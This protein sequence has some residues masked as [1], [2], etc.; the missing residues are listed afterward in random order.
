MAMT[1]LR[2]EAVAAA[3]EVGL[4]GHAV[5]VNAA[6]VAEAEDLEAA[7]VGQDGAVPG[8]EAVQPA[9]VA[10]EF[11]AGA[12]VEVVGVGQHQRRPQLAQIARPHRLDRGL[13]ADGGED[14]GF[15]RAVG[16]VEAAE[17]G[18]AVGGVDGEVEGHS[19]GL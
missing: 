15:Q 17:A 3:V 4:E 10:D 14:G 9:Q 12:Q 5:V 16:G 18:G 1:A 19:R 8:H 6:R 13:C 11:V 7:A 2:R